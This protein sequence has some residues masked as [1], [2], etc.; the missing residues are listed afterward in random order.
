MRWRGG[1]W[2]RWFREF[3]V[4]DIPGVR[5]NLAYL[6]KLAALRG[7]LGGA[8]QIGIDLATLL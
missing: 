4:E 3:E 2:G 7:S 8:S 1:W 5:L 6:A